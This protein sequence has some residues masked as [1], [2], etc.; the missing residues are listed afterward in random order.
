MRNNVLIITLIISLTLVF[1]S[2]GKDKNN[3]STYSVGGMV[4]GLSGTV[5]IQNNGKGD[6]SV[7]PNSTFTFTASFA[8]DYL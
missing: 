4:N 3:D 5:I 8:D 6:L 2:C 7:T 1:T